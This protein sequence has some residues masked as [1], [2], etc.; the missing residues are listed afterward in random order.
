MRSLF[1]RQGQQEGSAAGHLG[2]IF[3]PVHCDGGPGIGESGFVQTELDIPRLFRSR[4]QPGH[5]TIR[6]FGPIVVDSS[7]VVALGFFMQ[8]SVSIT[9]GT[10]ATLFMLF[11]GSL[12]C[13]KSQ[14]ASFVILGLSL[15]AVEIMLALRFP[16][17]VF[18]FAIADVI[19][20]IVAS[21]AWHTGEK[22]S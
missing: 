16:S 2:G 12:L 14:T 4:A 6:T 9:Y 17:L 13:W 22:D 8:S 18:P 1:H 3:D 5:R 11:A 7:D 15:L 20:L 10:G 21:G 19:L